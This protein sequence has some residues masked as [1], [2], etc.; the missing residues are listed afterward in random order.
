V[1]S[2]D[3]RIAAMP[4]SGWTVLVPVKRTDIAKSRLAELG[5]PVRRRLALAFADDVVGAARRCDDVAAVVVVTNDDVAADRLTAQGALVVPDTPDAG[6]NAALQFAAAAIRRRSPR[7]DLAVVSADLPAIRASD[8]AAA[9]R[10]AP[11]GRWFVPDRDA[12]GTTMLGAAAPSQ[13]QPAFGTSSAAAHS[14]SGALPLE[15]PELERL[16]LDVDT[17]ADLR[18]AAKLGVGAATQ[19]VLSELGWG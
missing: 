3:D 2:R 4:T 15:G 17:V 11:P 13:L 18:T 9:L 10:V 5:D 16:R 14:R 1:L 8:I 12:N 7:A 19:A 6:L